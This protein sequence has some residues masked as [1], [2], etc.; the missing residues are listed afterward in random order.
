MT[1]DP[2]VLAQE[3]LG[4][5]PFRFDPAPGP[6][7]VEGAA[8]TVPFRFLAIG[9]VGACAAGLFGLWQAGRLASASGTTGIGWLLAAVAMLALMGWHILT[10][11]T[12]IDPEALQQ[13][14]V[15]NKR[16][17]MRELAYAKLI[18]VRGLDWLIAPRLYVR[19]LLGKFAIFHVADPHVLE[20]CERL[21]AELKRFRRF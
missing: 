8:F 3:M 14:W 6:G 2:G 9:I 16:M 13:T 10:S 20:A 7:F 19:T 4:P 5:P 11:R 15:W 17:E 12:R 18:R 1:D 21:C